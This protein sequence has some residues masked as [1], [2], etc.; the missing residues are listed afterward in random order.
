MVAIEKSKPIILKIILKK[1]KVGDK[2]KV[3]IETSEVDINLRQG[4]NIYRYNIIDD[5]IQILANIFFENLVEIEQYRE[6]LRQY[7]DSVEKKKV[8]KVKNIT[9]EEKPIYKSY[10][11]LGQHQL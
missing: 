11:K 10:M 5:F 8:N 2:E 3:E 6:K 7:I 9:A 1:P 4:S